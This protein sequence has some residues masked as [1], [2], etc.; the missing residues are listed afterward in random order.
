MT[1]GREDETVSTEG[2]SRRHALTGVAAVGLGAPLLAACAGED[3][4]AT[5]AP[6]AG[7]RLGS[8]GDVPVG[9]GRV[10]GDQKVVVTQPAS[11]DFKAF[12]AVCTHQ[13]CLVSRIADGTIDCMCHG[14]K[15]SA[16]DGSVVIGPATEPL[17]EVA[18]TVD[19]ETILTS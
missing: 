7:E 10:F 14:S 18:I 4:T 8:T 19:G 2:I 16:T 1:A 15:F 3:E 13:S 11:G 5:E 6:P 12:S 17:A 9:G